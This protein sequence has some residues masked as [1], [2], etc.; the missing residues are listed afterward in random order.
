MISVGLPFIE[1]QTALYQRLV[2]DTTLMSLVTDVVDHVDEGLTYPY[3]VIGEPSLVFEDIKV[4]DVS[5]LSAT[6]HVWC[7][8]EVYSGN[9]RTY[10]ILNAI[11]EALKY[12]LNLQGYEV[13]KTAPQEPKV[14]DDIDNLTKHGVITYQFTLKRKG[15]NA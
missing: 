14:F 12:K 3:V 2:N 7:S 5:V 6:L 9:G 11:Y 1:L 13:V 15:A 10:Q 8:K 4:A